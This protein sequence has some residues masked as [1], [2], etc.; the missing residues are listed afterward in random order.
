MAA[1]VIEY[2]RFVEVQHRRARI[3]AELER[4]ARTPARLTEPTAVDPFIDVSESETS[5][6][7]STTRENG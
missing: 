2:A 4:A 5:V 7:A 1:T 6:D 3:V